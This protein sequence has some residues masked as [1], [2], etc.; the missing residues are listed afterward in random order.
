MKTRTGFVS[1]SSSS[2]FVIIAKPGSVREIIKTQDDLTQRVA[3]EY[4]GPYNCNKINLQG[5][6]LDVWNFVVH[7][8]NFGED[9]ELKSGED[10][11]DLY[12]KWDNLVNSL[13]QDARVKVL[14]NCC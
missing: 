7:T 11:D 8:E 9:V 12:H 10:Y 2:S 6:E 1:N 13:K 5:V 4:V 3:N 14:E